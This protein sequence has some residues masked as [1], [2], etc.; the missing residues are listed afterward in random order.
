MSQHAARAK[1]RAL[2]IAA[3]I[4]PVI[5]HPVGWVVCVVVA[6]TR[7]RPLRQWELNATI[8]TGRAPGFSGRLAAQWSW[9]RNTVGSLQLGTWSER[10]I[11]G[12][13][14]IDEQRFDE[15][16]ELAAGRGLVLALP[17][18]GSWD[19]AGAF[20][21]LSG[22]PVTSVAEKL[23]AGQFEYFSR[24][25]ARL[26]MNIH[27]FDQRGVVGLLADDVRNGRAICL[28]ADRDFGK[29][30]IAVTWPTPQGGREL[31][32]PAGPMLVAQQTGAALVPASCRFEGRRMDVRIGETIDVAPGR[33]GLH[34]AAQRLAEEFA[35]AVSDK[36]TDWHMMQRFFPGERA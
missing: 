14:T 34:D 33:Q 32:L 23:P 29:R 19:H 7:P 26:G 22:L 15:L 25:R 16:R 6:V 13:V 27:P 5:W 31:T 35:R 4:P 12:A 21:C 20:A 17:H 11:V 1:L 30:G 2:Q 3:H 9:L 10:R 24:M 36:P 8:A 18:M 28:V